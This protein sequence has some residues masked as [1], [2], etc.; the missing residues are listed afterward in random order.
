MEFDKTLKRYVSSVTEYVENNRQSLQPPYHAKGAMESTG[1]QQGTGGSADGR[2]EM[3]S[4]GRGGSQV[5]MVQ[6]CDAQD[7]GA[8]RL[9]YK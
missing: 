1:L 2:G 7:R 8:L 5:Y 6:D 3:S 4:N 9:G